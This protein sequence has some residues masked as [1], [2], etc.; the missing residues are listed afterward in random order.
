LVEL[1]TTFWRNPLKYPDFALAWG[2]RFTIILATFMFTTFRLLYMT[3]HLGLE[4]RDAT[5]AVAIG[6]TIYTV[7]SMIAGVLGGWLSDLLGRRKVL[8]AVSI[9]VFALATY[10]LLHADT[11]GAFY[12]VEAIMGVA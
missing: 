6:V 9:L 8:V 1:L 4:A 10:L 12:V 7:T 11:V 5:S 3:N 2:G